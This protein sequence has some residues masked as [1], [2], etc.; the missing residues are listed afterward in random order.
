M[1]QN[2]GRV[3]LRGRC[4]FRFGIPKGVPAIMQLA[5]GKNVRTLVHLLLVTVFK[6]H[7]RAALRQRVLRAG[8]DEQCPAA[9]C[10]W[11]PGVKL[12]RDGNCNNWERLLGLQTLVSCG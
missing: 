4:I 7:I 2:H 11:L 5:E 9:A 10:F 1:V 8:G 12:G 3:H 6:R